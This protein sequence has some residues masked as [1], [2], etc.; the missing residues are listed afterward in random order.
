MKQQEGQKDSGQV[1]QD[2]NILEKVKE[3]LRK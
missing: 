2:K 3:V 1:E